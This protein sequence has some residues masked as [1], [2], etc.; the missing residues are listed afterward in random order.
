MRRRNRLSRRR[1]RQLRMRLRLVFIVDIVPVVVLIV[2]HLVVQRVVMARRQMAALLRE[3]RQRRELNLLLHIAGVMLRLSMD[4]RLA[5]VQVVRLP[6]RGR[7]RRLL[8]RAGLLREAEATLLRGLLVE[9]I[10]IAA[11]ALHSRP[12]THQRA[13]AARRAAHRTRDSPWIGQQTQA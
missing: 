8:L 7:Q 6:R 5:D 9:R 13:I 10:A 12:C 2:L 4:G 11:V 1:R 3:E